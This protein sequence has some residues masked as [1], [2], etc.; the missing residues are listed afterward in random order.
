M[1]IR[2]YYVGCGLADSSFNILDYDK[3][4]LIRLVWT[5]RTKS[6]M[7]YQSEKDWKKTTIDQLF[8][9]QFDRCARV[10]RASLW[11]NRPLRLHGLYGSCPIEQIRV[12]GSWVIHQ[13]CQND[14]HACTSRLP[15]SGKSYPTRYSCPGVILPELRQLSSPMY[16]GT[17]IERMTVQ[18]DIYRQ[19]S[20]IWSDGESR[21]SLF[22]GESGALSTS[23]TKKVVYETL[24]PRLERWIA[25]F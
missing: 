13:G 24:R 22:F 25:W 19:K 9:I 14:C 17:E 10:W 1:K 8:L 15:L 21:S 6:I 11:R 3:R 20:M 4:W 5:I 12:F 18:S 16:V 2:L 23:V 7:N